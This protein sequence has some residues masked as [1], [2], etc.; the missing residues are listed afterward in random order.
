[1]KLKNIQQVKKEQELTEKSIKDFLF[2][3]FE[4]YDMN[5]DGRL[6]R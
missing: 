1:M 3:T 6:S 4:K 2:N 5:G